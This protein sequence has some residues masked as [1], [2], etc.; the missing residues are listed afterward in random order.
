MILTCNL[1]GKSLAAFV[2]AV[3]K[4]IVGIA[5][6]GVPDDTDK[7]ELYIHF[8]DNSYIKILDDM[9]SCCEHRYMTTDDKLDEYI[10]GSLLNI[11]VKPIPIPL[12]EYGDDNPNT[13]REIEFLEVTT[14]KGSFVI[15]NHNDHNGY[16]GGFNVEITYG[17]RA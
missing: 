15:V 5:L 4:E 3:G 6:S 8:K 2:K 17:E 9:Q 12:S 10:G 13:E 1:E 7:D 16:Y 11:E 14:T